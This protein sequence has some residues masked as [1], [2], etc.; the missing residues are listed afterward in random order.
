MLWTQLFIKLFLIKNQIINNLIIAFN[1][2]IKI[3][4]LYSIKN[5]FTILDNQFSVSN[6]N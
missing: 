2:Y 4:I 1:L 3:K 6:Y 5:Y